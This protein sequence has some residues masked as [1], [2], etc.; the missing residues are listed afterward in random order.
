MFQEYLFN[1]QNRSPLIHCITNMVTASWVV[2]ALTA[3]G[4]KAL[5][6]DSLD[7]VDAVLPFAQ[8]LYINLGTIN[9]RSMPAVQKAVLKSKALG[10]I[11]VL[12]P[13]GIS[14]SPYRA[15]CAK[16][17]HDVGH[18]DCIR[19]N[20]GEI[21]K[22]MEGDDLLE[23]LGIDPETLIDPN[24]LSTGIQ[25]A[26]LAARFYNTVVV[27]SGQV[28]L[29][30]DGKNCISIANGNPMM[31]RTV[32][33]GCMQSALIA[34]SLA[35]GNRKPLDAVVAAVAL[36]N[37]AGEIGWDNLA[38]NEGVASYRNRIIDALSNIQTRDFE[39]QVRY[40]VYKGD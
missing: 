5:L 20:A 29:I 2:D 6:A 34:A 28:D 24:Q 22:L 26:N 38:E 40:H 36:I 31:R 9:E 4:A 13:S 37:C 25:F 27:I 12:D 14:W 23:G 8:G 17:L 11:R 33:T 21:L 16:E 15:K 10:K 18:F 1:I 3:I 35:C 7:E 39:R 19:G 32:G 30:S